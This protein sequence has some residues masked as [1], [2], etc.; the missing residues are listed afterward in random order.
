LVKSKLVTYSKTR[1][2]LSSWHLICAKTLPIIYFVSITLLR[3][4]FSAAGHFKTGTRL[5]H[6]AP[7]LASQ[8][9]FYIFIPEFLSHNP[10]TPILLLKKHNKDFWN[11][12]AEISRALCHRNFQI[13]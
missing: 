9:P 12:Q 11:F 6:P 5:I 1:T 8:S 2:F 4:F 13:N 7:H 3:R 10:P